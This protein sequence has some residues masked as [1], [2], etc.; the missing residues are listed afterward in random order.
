MKKHVLLF[1]FF[2]LCIGLYAQNQYYYY[3]G[4]KQYLTLDKTKLDV[5]TSVHFKKEQVRSAEFEI[6]NLDNLTTQN[7]MF[8]SIKLQSEYKDTKYEE[9]INLLRNNKD[10]I[11]VHPNFITSE[12]IE[13]GMS[14]YFYVRLKEAVD[15]N[16]L[17][18]IAEQKNVVVVEQNKFLPL[19]YTLICTR[20]TPDN[21]LNIANYF[22]ETGLFASAVPDFLSNDLACTDDPDFSQLWGLHNTSY[23]NID[24][25]A[26]AAW[27]IT[28][29]GGVTVAV[30]DQGIELT[31]IDLEENISSLSYDSESNSSPS[32]IFG[33]HGTHCAGIIGA[34]RNNGTQIV[35]VA[36][37]CTL[38]SVSNSL[39]AG[40]D[41][42]PALLANSR[43]K[44]ADG[45]NWAWKNGADIISNSWESAVQYDAIDEAIDSALVYGRN[46][47]GT[48]IIFASGNNNDSIA[49]PANSNPDIIVVGAIA[50]NGKRANFSN[51]G[52]QLDVV[53]P[54]SG[55]LSTVLNNGTEKKSG[56]SMAAPHVAGVAA[57]I[58]SVNPNLTGLRVRNII[59]STAR[60]L[61]AHPPTELRP[62]G[63]WNN[64]VGYGLVNAHAAV[65]EAPFSIS[66]TSSLYNFQ[67]S[68]YT[69]NNLPAGTT[70]TWSSSSN[71]NIISGQGTSQVVISVC[72]GSTAT[73]TA[74]LSGA[75]SEVLNKALEVKAG[76]FSLIEYLGH[77]DVSL[78][79][80]YAL[81]FRWEIS[82]SFYSTVI[83]NNDSCRN[84]NNVLLFPSGDDAYGSVSV[85]AENGNCESSWR[86]S[87]FSLWRPTLSGNFNPMRPEPLNAYIEDITFPMMN[88]E[89]YWY[90][91]G[92][93]VAV[94]SEPSIQYWDWLCGEHVFSVVAKV[95]E[96]S[97]LSG[98]VDFWGM[99]SGGGG[100]RGVSAYPNPVGN[101][102]II[103][104]EINNNEI[105]INA[106]VGVQ[107]A[108]VKN[109]A[110]VKVLLYSHSTTKLVYSKDFPESSEQIRIDTSKF[111]NGI[112]YLNI[113]SNGE[114]I[115]EQ[116][117]VVKH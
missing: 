25:N 21:T 52:T 87:S 22:Y 69:I 99:C 14:P 75:V 115:K 32:R 106:T 12:N 64:Q 37:E 65:L 49:Y 94:T 53:A 97:S 111:P 4:E 77:V 28:R 73:L 72:K 26:C 35:G 39:G 36:P 89:F 38:M 67:Q 24:I 76:D 5:T 88:A 62:N 107:S 15:Y 84:Y 100:W 9:V 44:R 3:K 10:V 93:L 45:I 101:E 41:N 43:I 30:L 27:N 6:L 112:Y 57:L 79:N 42:N 86:G 66:G 11:A 71:V 102:L 74:T 114:K 8:G 113:I 7:L 59:E 96:E 91:D 104:R 40:M 110:T 13:I 80:P 108:K 98:S 82:N 95:G 18:K 33:Y 92:S 55:I 70:V 1:T 20:E 85:R 103:T 54:G 31:H 16:L 47:K 61:S 29:G 109:N 81:C 46:G 83:G 51:Y 34:A 48:I 68:T 117:I 116:T 19:W 17:K 78:N 105:N 63:E 56:T 23:P 2:L 90:F 58:L 60:N 50:I